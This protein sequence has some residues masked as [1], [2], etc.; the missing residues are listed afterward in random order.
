MVHGKLHELEMLYHR[1]AT[2]VHEQLSVPE[3][4]VKTAATAGQ[5]C[6]V[7]FST[8]PSMIYLDCQHSLRVSVSSSHIK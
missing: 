2:A 5:H 7:S 1:S 3:G 4:F 8:H 6:P